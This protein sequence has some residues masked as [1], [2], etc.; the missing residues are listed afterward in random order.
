MDRKSLTRTIGFLDIAIEQLAA[1]NMEHQVPE[2]IFDNLSAALAILDNELC[3][4]DDERIP[5]DFQKEPKRYT[6]ADAYEEDYEI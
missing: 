3:F 6:K 1:F 4:D 5:L 2:I